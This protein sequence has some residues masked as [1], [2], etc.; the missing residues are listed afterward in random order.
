MW[1]KRGLLFSGLHKLGARATF[2]EMLLLV[3]GL[4]AQGLHTWA[5][6]DMVA[7]RVGI[8]T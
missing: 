1:T 3:Q 7:A 2:R 5:A 6:K 4:A 8:L